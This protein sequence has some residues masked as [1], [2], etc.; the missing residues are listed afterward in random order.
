MLGPGILVRSL[1]VA[2]VEDKHGNRWSYH[3]RSD[4][5]SKLAC[6]G[7]VFDLLRACPLLRQHVSEGKVAFGIN[8]EMRDFQH[9]RKKNLDL[10]FCTPG[11][12]VRPAA[13]SFPELVA[14]Y[15]I[16]LTNDE[17]AILRSLPLLR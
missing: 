1:S 5:H 12:G 6:W 14:H 10:V 13:A 17:E 3:S 8:H 7:I 9:N 11:S 16:A 4:R 15:Q 2:A